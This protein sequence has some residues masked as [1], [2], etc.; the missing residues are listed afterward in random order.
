MKKTGTLNQPLSAAIAGLG[1][2]DTP[3]EMVPHEQFKTQTAQ[4]R[5]VVGT[6]EFSP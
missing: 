2:T 1:H 3:L 6:G 4:A 5:A